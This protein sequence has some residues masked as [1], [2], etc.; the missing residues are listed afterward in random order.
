MKAMLARVYLFYPAAIPVGIYLFS[1]L[2]GWL[3]ATFPAYFLFE[4]EAQRF[5]MSFTITELVGGAMTGFAAIFGVFR[6]WGIKP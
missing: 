3:A 2:A 1:L 5:T 6:T 4:T